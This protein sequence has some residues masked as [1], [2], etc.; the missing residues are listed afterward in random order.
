MAKSIFRMT[1]RWDWQNR[2]LALSV[3]ELARFSLQAVG[4]SGSGLWRT[5][6]GRQWH[7]HLRRQ[8]ESSDTGWRFEQAVSG[9]IRQGN[10]RFAL[11]G[12]LDQLQS[13]THPP[14]LRE[15]KTVSRPLPAPEEALR[16]AYPH[17]FHQALLYGFLMAQSGSLPATELLLVEIQTG[18]SQTIALGDVDYTALREHLQRVVTELEARREHL[19]RLRSME[20]PAPFTQWRS[21]QP[22]ARSALRDSLAEDRVI[23]FEAPTGFGKTGLVLEA[24][25]RQLAAGQVDRLLLLTGKNTGHAALLNQIT[26]F[27]E[28]CPY[29]TAVALRSRQDLELDPERERGMSALEILERW[30]ESGLSAPRLLADGIPDRQELLEL[31]RRHGVPPWALLRLLLPWADIWIADYNY[32]FD[33]AVSQVFPSLPTWAPGRTLLVV[34]EAHNLPER[35]AASRSHLLEAPAVE[36][37][38]T[39]IQFARFPGRLAA[40]LDRLL[41]LLKPLARQEEV[42]PPEEAALLDGIRAVCAALASAYPDETSCSAEVR[43]WLFD[44]PR[45]LEDWEHPEL[46]F[47]LHCPAR[48]QV[49]FSCLDAAPVVRPVLHAFARTVLMSATLQPWDAFEASIGLSRDESARLLGS[50]DWLRAAFRVGVDARIDTRYRMRERFHNALAAVLGETARSHPGQTVAFFPSYRY[51]QVLLERLQFHFPDLR[52]ALQPRHLALEEQ[53]AFL[54]QSLVLDDILLLILGSRFS[55]GIDALGG[56]IRRALVVGPALPEVNGLQ[57]AREQRVCGGRETAFH[58]VYR[59]PGMRRINQ[60]LGRLVRDP[61]QHAEVLLVGQRFLE[62]AYQQLLPDYLQP[63]FSLES[64]EDFVN[65]WLQST[66]DGP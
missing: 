36:R 46:A 40:E 27:R 59:I 60:A 65:C 9:E 28:S 35:A 21:G 39:E 8:L 18:L 45:L 15:V 63:V 19:G 49:R 58:Q 24:A 32:L 30:Q 41:S 44:L 56:R 62:P 57:K 53:E 6:I 54:E 31:G 14:L 23:L 66:G 7:E 10:W 5:E 52:C 12:R 42:E 2:S 29:L 11:Q 22:E 48:G 20:I 47:H 64:R 3:G 17:Y 38:V 25:L 4:D 61:D 33:S 55:E 1:M 50:A 37:A 16:A 34:D 51:A 13:G 26:R 43:D